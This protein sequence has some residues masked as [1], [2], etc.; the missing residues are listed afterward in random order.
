MLVLEV[1]AK[2]F[3]LD[4]LGPLHPIQD[5]PQVVYF[6][7]AQ[8][9]LPLEL[10][11]VPLSPLLLVLH[12]TQ[13]HLD[14]DQLLLLEGLVQVHF[15]LTPMEPQQLEV[16]IV[17]S[18]LDLQVPMEAMLVHSHLDKKQT[19]QLQGLISMPRLL[20][21]LAQLLK[22]QVFNMVHSKANLLH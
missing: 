1:K 20:Q 16:L 6:H 14:L 2:V 8:A 13:S 22:L 18:S 5:L 12:P 15:H 11:Q 10:L 17:L 3:S 19:K 7:L 9:H 4:R 21:S